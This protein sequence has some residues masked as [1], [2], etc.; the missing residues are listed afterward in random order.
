MTTKS[1]EELEHFKR[2]SQRTALALLKNPNTQKV[3]Q[4]ILECAERVCLT[5]RDQLNPTIR[6]YYCHQRQCPNCQE[7]R[8]QK[9]CSEMHQM[10]DQHPGLAQ[11]Q[12][13]YLTLTVRNCNIW[14]L[15]EKLLNMT[16]AYQR[17]TKRKFFQENV[18]GAIRFTEVNVGQSEPNTAH[19]H[20]HCM[21]LVRPSMYSGNNYVSQGRWTE[22]WQSALQEPY[23]PKVHIQRISGPPEDVR[24]QVIGLAGYSTKARTDEPDDQWLVAI[25]QELKNLNLM[26]TSGLLQTMRSQLSDYS[27]FEGNDWP[28][29]GR[30][31]ASS[32][33]AWDGYTYKNYSV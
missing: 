27:V 28:A 31:E 18:I 13:L 10:F 6:T 1:M 24:R 26:Q 19:P 14:D 2:K 25:T 32:V 8:S 30:L 11:Q 12:W 16:Q 20:F 5:Y 23:A 17:V 15:R 7:R 22:A 29:K 9:I 3:G 21:L 4:S 33:F